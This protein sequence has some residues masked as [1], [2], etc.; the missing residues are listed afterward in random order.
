MNVTFPIRF[1]FILSLAP[2]ALSAAAPS[3]ET[4]KQVLTQRLQKL[5]PD[6]MAER[7]VLYQDVRAG[8]PSGGYYPF[9]VTALIR[10]YG[11][12]YPANRYYGQ[13]CV[14]RLDQLEFTLHVDNYG[15]WDVQ[16]AMTPPMNTRQ[17]KPN[18]SAGATSIPLSALSGT[19]AP[20]GNPAPPPAEPA[21]TAT[22]TRGAGGGKVALGGYECWGNGS[23]RMLLNFTVQSATQYTGSD[24][25]SGTYNV[26]AGGRITFHGGALDGAMPT[27]FYAVYY[28]P[29]GVPTVSFRSPRDSEASFCQKAR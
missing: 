10:D 27:G 17:C 26:D 28:E 6:G 22:T 25:K 18:P 11:P 16:G 3:T 21:R 19:P 9:Q 12:G 24:G 23:A 20:A 4:L 14:G 15:A 2:V 1:V 5:I 8:A 29:K 13:T 7:Q